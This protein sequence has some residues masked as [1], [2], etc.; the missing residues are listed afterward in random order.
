MSGLQTFLYTVEVGKG[1]VLA[2]IVP[3][4]VT[5]LIVGVLYDFGGINIPFLGPLGGIY[6]GLNDAQSMDN[7]QLA[8][9]IVRGAGYTTMFLRPQAVAQLNDYIMSRGGGPNLFP[10]DR[11]PAGTPR[12]LPDTYNAPGYPCL[13]AAWFRILR[14]PF[15]LSPQYMADH[16][17]FN[18]EK[19]IPELNQ[20]FMILTALLIFRLGLR[21]FDNRV[22]WISTVAFLASDMIWQ[23]SIT[24]LSTSFLMFLV[25]GM[26]LAAAE[27]FSVG[28]ACIENTERSFGPAW[29]WALVLVLLLATACLTRLHLLVLLVPLLVF[30]IL[31]PRASFLLAPAIAILV[32]GAVVPWFWHTYKICGNPFGSN[33]PLLFYGTDEYKGNQIYCSL[34]AAHYNQFFKDASTKEFLGFRWHF[35]RAW[36]LLGSNPMILLFGASLLHPF[37]RP[38]AQAFRWFI[39]GS[40]ICVIAAN[41]LCNAQPAPVSPWNTLVVLFPAMLVIGSAFFFILLD[42][43][44]LQVQLLNTLIVITTLLLTAVPLTL[45]LSTPT[46]KFYNYPPYIPGDINELGRYALPEEWVTSDMP[47]ATA[48]YGDHASLWLPDSVADFQKLYDNA[49]P[50]GILLFTPVTLDAPVTNLTSGEYKDW[51]PFISEKNLPPSFPL[52]THTRPAQ[53]IPEYSIWSDRPRWQR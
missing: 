20:I 22:A 11:F 38:R 42:R 26:L 45:T 16:P 14:P 7:A 9:Q 40:A 19:W 15:D 34:A 41:N 1:R 29:L 44:N 4:I 53:S 48:W 30:L 35:E 50:T 33:L 51:F 27:I 2:R 39:V 12:M 10:P 18:A 31:M 52:T 37:K 5:I 32:I 49:C 23:Y 46:Y 6:H 13:L 47:W 3:L 28:E 17:I 25:T 21:L 24:G 8:R 36:D 43:L